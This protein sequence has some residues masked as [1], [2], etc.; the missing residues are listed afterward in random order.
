MALDIFTPPMQPTVGAGGASEVK[1][2]RIET[3]MGDGYVQ[4]IGD[5]IN[6]TPA[7]ATVVWDPISQTNAET[8][9]T[10]MEAHADGKAF[11]YRLP[12]ENKTRAWIWTSRRRPRSYS[13]AQAY[14]VELR[15][16]FD[17]G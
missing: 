4:R 8:I 14:I 10:F 17:Q 13:L 2:R 15:E 6:L 9:E 16:V 5:G 12:N 11:L 7:V 1:P 3:S